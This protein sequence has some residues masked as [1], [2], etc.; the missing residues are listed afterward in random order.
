MDTDNSAQT[1]AIDA[2]GNATVEQPLPAASPKGRQ[3]KR[4]RW[5]RTTT[6]AGAPRP[7][8]LAEVP[9]EVLAEILS[10]TASTRDLLALARCSKQFCATLVDNPATVYI[11]RRA[12]AR[13]APLPIPDPT[14]NFTEYSYAAFLF[15]GGECEICKAKT[16]NMYRWFALR[17][18]ICDKSLCRTKWRESVMTIT[19]AS[20]PPRYSELLS[21]IPRTEGNDPSVVLWVHDA[22]QIRATDWLAAV[23]EFNKES[24]MPATLEAYVRR[25]QVLADRLPVIMEHA[26]K[27]AQW[28]GMRESFTKQVKS[29]NEAKANSFAVAE[30]WSAWDL[31]HTET[32]GLLHRSKILSL[33]NVKDTDF[34]LIR[35]TVEREIIANKE[36]QERCA[37][38]H[39][40]SKR[41]A[42][43]KQHYDRLRSAAEKQVLPPLGEFRKLSVMRLMQEK[44]SDAAAGISQELKNSKLVAELL[45]DNLRAWREGAR[46]ALAAALGFPGWKSFS[47]KK[48]H[49][50]E[51]LNA[52]FKCK[53]CAKFEG[54]SSGSSNRPPLP[55]L[56]FAA[57]C[58]HR[59][60][61][62]NKRKR[63]RETWSADHF[64]PDQPVIDATTHILKLCSIDPEESD[65]LNKVQGF[66]TSFGCKS[67][68]S[69]LVMDFKSMA[70]H[71]K[72]HD[73]PQF[74]RRLEQP[75]VIEHGLAKELRDHPS[76]D[77]IRRAELVLYGCRH[78]E[79]IR[80]KA[81]AAGTTDK[82]NR[83][84]L[85]GKI[86][87]FHGL[88]SHV[89]E[90]HG[91]A[92][93]ADEDFFRQK[94]PE[95][96]VQPGLVFDIDAL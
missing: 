95:A 26:R 84:A 22:I 69:R 5:R 32:Y 47:K 9:L 12:R 86:Y 96:P 59:C 72:R 76:R 16:R 53:K 45:K 36:R 87:T 41:R 85:K 30:G 43:V 54:A 13:C 68:P 50:V 64:E 40:Y 63:A 90:K 88:R 34:A 3:S 4:P 58:E 24:R 67:C 44:P 75:S 55:A 65:S 6:E 2:S 7:C 11:W 74:C 56:D 51:R 60:P 82:S 10:H 61:H 62:L 35:P 23:D 33:E 70:Q 80:V 77:A 94:E 89:K 38:E 27:L 93:I 81:G 39:A 71:C 17:L 92:Q 57:A 29:R 79:Q 31:L 78:C 1:A 8:Y 15:D 37:A 21:W 28:R 49:P 46:D 83:L 19:L 20:V 73:N 52:W 66:G 14:P 91:I 42:D 25:K 18:R 48:L